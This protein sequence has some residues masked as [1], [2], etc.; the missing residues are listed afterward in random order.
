MGGLQRTSDDDDEKASLGNHTASERAGSIG[1]RR[2]RRLKY[3]STQ[4]KLKKLARA[5]QP[6]MRNVAA[7]EQPRHPDLCRSARHSLFQHTIS[8]VVAGDASRK[9]PGLTPMG[10]L[11]TPG[12]Q[13]HISSSV[14]NSLIGLATMLVSPLA[15]FQT[16]NGT[17]AT[18]QTKRDESVCSVYADVYADLRSVFSF[19]KNPKSIFP[20]K[21]KR[22]HYTESFMASDLSH[23]TCAAFPQKH[24]FYT[25]SLRPTGLVQ[26]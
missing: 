15:P 18:K 2:S 7:N 1:Q 16:A 9:K 22:K 5:A 13:L 10:A 25:P 11:H 4:M 14:V 6:P 20:K 19:P 12:K 24:D 17:A 3:S 26:G 8:T 23:P 21:R